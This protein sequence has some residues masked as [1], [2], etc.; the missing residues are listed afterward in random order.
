MSLAGLVSYMPPHGALLSRN[1]A[2]LDDIGS[3]Q[4]NVPRKGLGDENAAIGFD[5]H[6]WAQGD[7]R[8][9][10]SVYSDEELSNEDNAVSPSE[11]PGDADTVMSD[12]PPTETFQSSSNQAISRIVSAEE[13]VLVR[14]GPLGK[15]AFTAINAIER[16]TE[17]EVSS[18]KSTPTHPPAVVGASGAETHISISS[19]DQSVP[20][21]ISEVEEESEPEDTPRKAPPSRVTSEERQVVDTGLWL[22]RKARQRKIP[23]QPPYSY[24]DF[25][26]IA[27][28]QLY[29]INS[30][31]PRETH[32]IDFHVAI[33]YRDDRVGRDRHD[34]P[35]TRTRYR[36]LSLSIHTEVEDPNQVFTPRQLQTLH[37][38]AN[39]P[40]QYFHDLNVVRIFVRSPAHIGVD[41]D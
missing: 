22:V 2:H 16:L 15:S 11:G 9:A 12:D 41:G 35:V 7:D 17:A 19:D 8:Y 4:P 25:L 28:T 30:V 20:D 1:E 5:C 31:M 33:M 27:R 34:Q 39:H 38:L 24:R 23:F 26:S 10:A 40:I 29:P 21:S 14:P 37:R 18:Q 32:P 6:D 3:A 13:S 36:C